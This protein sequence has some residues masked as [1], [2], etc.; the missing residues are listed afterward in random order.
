MIKKYN[1][2]TPG[3]RQMTG[4][5][6]S[7]LSKVEP[8][9]SLKM[10]L[11]RS[12]GRNNQ[13]RITTLHKGGGV[14]R[15]YRMIDFNQ[16]DKLDIPA[17]VETIEYDPNRSARIA[18]ILY[19]DGSRSYILAPD[20]LKAGDRVTS[21]SKTG[22]LAVGNRLK[23]RYIPQGTQIYN[24]ELQP[25]KGGQ[26]VR[27]A[28][29]TAQM[30]AVEDDKYVQVKMP[31]GEVRRFLADSMASIGQLSNQ[32]HMHISLG[33]AGRSRW[34]GRRPA[35][36]GTA[37]NPVDHPHGGG[38]GKQ[39][40]GMPPKTPWGKKAMGVKTRKRKKISNRLIVKRRK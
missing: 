39:P 17:R 14:K 27:S 18:R 15:S 28:G 29:S 33:K 7:N 24:I 32:E 8:L 30:L 22:S 11:R 21:F 1:P 23:L 35:V 26:I 19:L 6:F 12:V 2:T 4:Y 34:L 5:D 3:R 31:S 36:R 40:L 13:G 10:G 20:S 16:L 9:R 25:G 38:E 37:M